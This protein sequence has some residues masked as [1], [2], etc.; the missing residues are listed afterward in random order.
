MDH[1]RV[2]VVP[3]DPRATI[4]PPRNSAIIVANE[5]R[6]VTLPV[7]AAPVPVFAPA[8]ATIIHDEFLTPTGV[9][10]GRYAD[11]VSNGN[12]WQ[13]LTL[14]T[15]NCSGGVASNA[16]FTAPTNYINVGA[17]RRV[18]AT[19]YANAGTAPLY[20]IIC[21]FVSSGN[22]FLLQRVEGFVVRLFLVQDSVF[23][24][25]GQY[26]SAFAGTVSKKMLLATNN[27]RVEGWLE[28]EESSKIGYNSTVHNSG[29]SVGIIQRSIG[30]ANFTDFKATDEILA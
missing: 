18:S 7:T 27:D 17:N 16:A 8:V 12:Q 29:V 15:F 11:V 4:I 1:S 6:V 5:S 19:G 30:V 23:T 2:I 26:T 28:G 21:R 3:N 9:L 10:N 13:K 22:Y 20:G 14:D 25:V 24:N